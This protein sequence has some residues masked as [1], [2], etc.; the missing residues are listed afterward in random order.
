MDEEA[1]RQKARERIQSGRLPRTESIRAW[2]GPGIGQPCVVCD[3]PI[4]DRETEFEL[5][6]PEGRTGLR[7]YRFHRFCQAAWEMERH[8]T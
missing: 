3:E 5:Q 4:T 6:F 2:A 7:G 8:R 1:I